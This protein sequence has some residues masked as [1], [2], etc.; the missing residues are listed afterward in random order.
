MRGGRGASVKREG[1]V[2]DG[3]IKGCNLLFFEARS[4]RIRIVDCQTVAT[5][6]S[7]KTVEFF[8]S[9]RFVPFFWLFPRESTSA[10]RDISLPDSTQRKTR[11]GTREEEAAAAA[12]TR[13]R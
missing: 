5:K 3:E 2:R 1:T 6:W 13:G 12:A 10:G 7:R 4:K 11:N 9:F 8:R